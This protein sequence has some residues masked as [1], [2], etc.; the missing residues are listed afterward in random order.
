MELKR[1]LADNS[2]DALQQVKK[3]HGEDALI[4]S[5][6]KIGK[7]T[8][9]ICAIEESPK[10]ETTIRK[11]TEQN[12]DE[13][14]SNSK[15][16]TKPT[17]V[18]KELGEDIANIEFSEQLGRIVSKAELKKPKKSPDINELMKTIQADLSDLRNKLEN[19]ANSVAPIT[20]AR[21]ALNAF[22]KR[23][24]FI[25]QQ[26]QLEN[27]IGT[28]LE[29][30]LSEQRNWQGINI[31]YGIPGSGKTRIVESIITGLTKKDSLPDC[32]LIE[33]SSITENELAEF[34]NLTTLGQ[35]FNIACFKENQLSNLLDRLD[36]LPTEHKIFIEVSY[37]DI[38]VAKKMLSGRNTRVTNE[39]LCLPA[40]STPTALSR[41]IE[42]APN[43][44]NSIIMTRMDLVPDI[45]DML[46]FLAE[47]AASVV[48]VHTHTG[49]GQS[50]SVDL[51][52]KQAIKV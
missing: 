26:N 50:A 51:S 34:N 20:K 14:K 12:R 24:K 5:T 45:N 35:R 42:T 10:V 25:E 6:N 21:S 30:K 38:D 37:E 18:T 27:S 36:K 43:L 48:G 3:Q 32:T 23:D 52:S 17:N 49:N 33:F 40:D 16:E 13:L 11:Q 46:S 19:Q 1:F 15:N 8:E 2:R 47:F 9:V 39:F 29:S 41:V 4:I 28:L 44:L 7:K 22:G 31:F